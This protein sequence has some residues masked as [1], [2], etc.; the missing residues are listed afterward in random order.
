MWIQPF[1]KAL[2]HAGR[3][4]PPFIAELGPVSESPD[5]DM[6]LDY[7]KALQN[8]RSDR[9]RR[10][11]WELEERLHCPVIGTCLSITDL[12]RL[13]RQSGVVMEAKATDFDYHATLAHAA[14]DKS[15]VT[16]NLQKLLDKRF[17]RHVRQLT[18]VR[19][20][21]EL[22]NHWAQAL[23]ND[24]IPGMLWAVVTHPVITSALSN[25]V[26]G[27]IHMLSHLSGRSHR[28]A[29]ARIPLLEDERNSLQEM[30]KKQRTISEEQM[31]ERD[32]RIN[33]LEQMVTKLRQDL[34]ARDT[35]RMDPDAA[36]LN[37]ALDRQQRRNEWLTMN[38]AATRRE[39]DE[40]NESVKAMKELLQESREQLSSSEM[41]LAQLT[42]RIGQ[43][44]QQTSNSPN[45]AG[46]KVVYIGGRRSLEPHLRSLVEGYQGNFIH[47]D[48][49][50][51]DSRANLDSK[52]SGADVVFCPIDCISHDACQ[53]VKRRCKRTNTTFI[54]LPSSGISSLLNGLRQV[55]EQ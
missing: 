33:Q 20:E 18:K 50:V 51:E 14:S 32:H 25:Q 47:H 15:R 46:R 29:L 49:G 35:K 22:A 11:I 39:L 2:A 5:S 12:K 45:L 10:K 37:D 24:E 31:A 52:L 23:A 41:S 48:G 36:A 3:G 6:C 34:A 53:R 9:K 16:K 28:K 43:D 40:Q 38:L 26:Y 55:T 13:V 7:V 27:E 21:T 44:C 54:P 17:N 42:E 30:L 4:K 1:I 8:S 19:C